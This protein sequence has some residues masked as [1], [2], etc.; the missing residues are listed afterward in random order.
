MG[1]AV[2]RLIVAKMVWNF[3]MDL[4]V[5]SAA[6]DWLDQKAFFSWEKKP[7]KVQIRSRSGE[8]ANL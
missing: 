1:E 2:V 3:D 8:G 5:G 4:D 6:T 7:L